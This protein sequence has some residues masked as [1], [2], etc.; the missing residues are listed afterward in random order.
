MAISFP[1]TEAYLNGSR[2]LDFSL[3]LCSNERLECLSLPFRVQA[4]FFIPI[5][6]SC[7]V[8]ITRGIFIQQQLLWRK[9]ACF[10]EW[11]LGLKVSSVSR[12]ILWYYI[13]LIQRNGF[14][15]VNDCRL[16]K[17]WGCSS[18]KC[19][20]HCRTTSLSFNAASQLAFW[21]IVQL[22]RFPLNVWLN[23][24]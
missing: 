16:G 2:V 4:C 24:V 12:F 20:L 6:I 13:N 17:I 10:R 21:E 8:D 1:V 5:L 23:F 14:N 22:R 7:T 15:L 11:R 19:I 18:N 3:S 9:L